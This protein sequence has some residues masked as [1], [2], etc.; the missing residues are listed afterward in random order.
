M[1]IKKILLAASMMVVVSSVQADAYFDG[2]ISAMKDSYSEA[3]EVLKPLADKGDPRAIFNLG[4]MYHAGLFVAFDE[5]KAVEMYHAAAE[6][7]VVEAQQFLAAAYREGWFGLQ[8]DYQ[9]YQYWMS[10][11]GEG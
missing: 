5:Q 10:A 1:S 6:R 7:G 3:Y 8:M 4:L 9:K 11:Q 2:V